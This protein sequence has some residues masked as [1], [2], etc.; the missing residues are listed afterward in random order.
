[1]ISLVD[2]STALVMFFLTVVL[3]NVMRD[4]DPLMGYVFSGLT[5]G[6]II[7]VGFVYFNINAILIALGAFGVAELIALVVRK[8]TDIQVDP[9]QSE[10]SEQEKSE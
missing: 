4:I 10:S 3:I 6:I 2:V 7:I 8:H 1:M 5:V 9:T